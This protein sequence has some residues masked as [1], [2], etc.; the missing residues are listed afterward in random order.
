MK[1]RVLA[2]LAAG[3]LAFVV[4]ALAD[5]NSTESLI[6]R[7]GAVGTLNIMTAEEAQAARAAAAASSTAAT[8]VAAGPTDGESIY[9]S[10]C[11]ACHSTGV[12]GSPMLG[13]VDNWAPR[14]AQG[15]EVLLD[16]AIN[17]F[18]GAAGVM[19]AKGGNASLSDEQVASAVEY[20]IEASR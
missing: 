6:Q 3:T 8:E 12:A 18:Q 14:I 7:I 15:M 9:N 1:R 16:H 4:S 19:P 20:M 17:G 13:D 11:L 10:A 5:H 2:S